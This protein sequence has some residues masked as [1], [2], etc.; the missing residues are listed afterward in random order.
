MK[1]ETLQTLVLAKVMI[2]EA[3]PRC[4]SG[5]SYSASAGLM[6]LQDGVEL[7]LIA[8]LSERGFDTE[9]LN[10]YQ[11]IAKI[12]DSG[13]EVPNDS[14]MKALNKQRVLIKHYG[15]LIE[16]VEAARM[17][18]EVYTILD[19]ILQD[20]IGKRIEDIFLSELIS[21][22][23]AKKHLNI[24]FKCIDEG[25]FFD[26]LV[27]IRKA[28]FLE[29][30]KDYSIEAYQN[31]APGGGLMFEGYKAHWTNKNP[32]WIAEHVNSPLDFIQVDHDKMRMD[33]LE[34]GAATNDYWN[35][36]RLTPR[37]F[38]SSK[39]GDWIIEHPID[40]VRNATEEGAKFCLRLAI[41][42]IYRKENHRRGARMIDHGKGR[43]IRIKAKKPIPVYEKASRESPEVCVI[44]IDRE[45]DVVNRLVGLD[46]VENLYVV[47][48]PTLK[49]G[50]WF[51]GYAIL[52]EGGF[53]EVT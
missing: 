30:E 21:D 3:Q 33:C 12:N 34:W 53:E 8:I 46:D 7:V 20:A 49:L 24:A 25:R 23:E 51:F 27:E 38:R 40:K 11:C 41:D 36:W 4:L 45:L 22:S 6:L 9:K 19:C 5:D 18:N 17:Y 14:V 13:I 1:N 29:I 2:E 10:Y 37:V 47:Q 52:E 16:P 43:S 39:G 26:A 28:I 44:D 15:R 35:I 31:E 50:E 48:N 42:L 32:K